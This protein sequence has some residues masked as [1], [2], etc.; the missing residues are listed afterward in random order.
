MSF[1]KIQVE[2]NAEK[3]RIRKDGFLSM[4]TTKSRAADKPQED[5]LFRNLCGQIAFFALGLLCSKATVFGEYA[6]FGVALAA[7]APGTLIWGGTAGALLGYL[8]P[9]TARVPVHYLA[10]LLAGGALRWALNDLVKP[11]Q[12]ALLS[13]GAAGLSVLCTGLCV[14]VVNGAS[15]GSTALF[16]AESLLSGAWGYFFA[17][18]LEVLWDKPSTA[19]LLPQDL[20]CCAFS[21]GAILLALSG[22]A[23]EGVSLGRILAVLF[24][25]YAA[26]FG[27]AAGGAVSG[28]GAGAAFA[29]STTGLN[30]L[31]GAYALGGLMAG[32]FSP[33]GKL[34]GA[35]AFIMANVIA[36]LQIG[37]TPTVFA[38]IYEVAIA[39][40]V[41]MILPSRVGARFLRF[42]VR[43][44]D[45][46][47]TDG[48]RRSIV[49]RLDFTAQTMEKISDTV[50]QV[51]DKLDEADQLESAREHTM[52][53]LP[54]KNL[55][56]GLLIQQ[57][58][59][60]GT[61]LEE[62]ASDLEIYERCD[63]QTARAVREVLRDFNMTPVDVNCVVDRFGR[64]KVEAL[65]TRSGAGVVNKAQLAQE[66]SRTC[67]RRFNPPVIVRIGANWR[68]VFSE[69][70]RYRVLAGCA[71]HSCNNQKLCGDSYQYFSDG[72]GHEIA[73]LSDGMGTGGR[74]AVD[75]TMAADVFSDLMKA[76][77]GFDSALKIVN[78]ALVVKSVDESLATLDVLSLDL[79]TGSV[80]FYKAGAPM[81]FVRRDGDVIPI[82][83]PGVPVGILE[84]AKFHKINEEIDAGDLIILLSDG[85]LSSG[86]NWIADKISGW[87]DRMP[88]ELAESIV[89][90]AVARRVDGHD[91]DITVLV[92][93]LIDNH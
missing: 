75:G 13:G 67:S 3:R 87:D 16:V 21:A 7:A 74:A 15:G 8:L 84:E 82:D 34:A 25:L 31:S 48:L 20:C 79:Y 46:P 60:V 22:V 36:S 69:R 18:T 57:F 88:Q 17:R 49:S 63:Y 56:R 11:S 37:S 12:K 41:Y 51:G 39:T 10:A 45:A 9:G 61:V 58:S 26:R 5:A 40:V 38:G 42:F 24:I 55:A 83:A 78:S 65:A 14:A 86:A 68:M 72:Q 28:I 54:G 77:I 76:G 59:T 29:L 1:G 80:E 27:G 32:L 89:A 93:K 92:F 2:K 52:P 33:L 70:V 73:V 43:K 90:E 23:V 4:T 62:M 47:R 81:S 50:E 44:D 53:T 66:I 6:P 85:A 64:M 71:R 19:G 35:C 91:D 30:Y